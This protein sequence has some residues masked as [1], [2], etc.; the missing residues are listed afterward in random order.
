M[1][2]TTYYINLTGVE[3]SELIR[4]L[5]KM[6]N[7]YTEQGKYTDLIDETIYKVS[8]AKIKKFKVIPAK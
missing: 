6:K 2:S 5:I 8:K 1:K 4:L 7:K 3:R